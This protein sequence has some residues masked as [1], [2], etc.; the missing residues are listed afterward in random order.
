MPLVLPESHLHN[1]HAQD[2][3]HLKRSFRDFNWTARN[4]AEL[5]F[6]VLVR[7]TDHCYSRELD[8]GELQTEEHSV[9]S[10]GPPKRV[11]CLER[12][13]ETQ[14]LCLMINRLLE[15]PNSPVSLTDGERNW[16][17]YHSYPSSDERFGSH[18]CAFFHLKQ[19]GYVEPDSPV[20]P[21]SLYVESAHLRLNKGAIVNQIP[22]GRAAEAA[23]MGTD[24]VKSLGRH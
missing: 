19:N 22:F 11:F 13:G 21:L 24:A 10:E 12:Y 14:R 17:T 20:I 23:M 4:G 18:Y 6:H 1:G 7:Y 16:M 2:L 15:K 8:D 5:T 9:V 3:R